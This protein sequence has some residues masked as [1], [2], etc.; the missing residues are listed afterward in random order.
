MPRL[1]NHSSKSS[2]KESNEKK[3]KESPSNS[4]SV[5]INSK[6]TEL[7]NARKFSKFKALL[8]I[9]P[10]SNKK[11]FSESIKKLLESS[12]GKSECKTIEGDILKFWKKHSKKDCDEYIKSS[13]NLSSQDNNKIK[14]LESSYDN[15]FTINKDIT[16]QLAKEIMEKESLNIDNNTRINLLKSWNKHDS[17]SYSEYIEEAYDKLVMLYKQKNNIEIQSIVNNFLTVEKTSASG[18]IYKFLKNIKVEDLSGNE[19]SDVEIVRT[20]LEIWS[21]KDSQSCEK[22]RNEIW[23]DW[24]KELTK[25]D[26]TIFS[27]AIQHIINKCKEQKMDYSDAD[28]TV[29][30]VNKLKTGQLSDRYAIMDK[31][32]LLVNTDNCKFA[33]HQLLATLTGS[34]R[35]VF[36]KAIRV[37]LNIDNTEKIYQI[38]FGIQSNGKSVG[39]DE[40]TSM[41]DKNA[42]KKVSDIILMF[43]SVAKKLKSE[44]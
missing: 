27:E 30:V 14:S 8:H 33:K 6:L 26:N 22:Y 7:Y 36:N 5:K 16:S 19:K 21:N 12:S 35:T 2:D 11:Q 3:P 39:A 9:L 10:R 4:M 17:N 31:N 40:L 34:I 44:I 42:D 41:M 25:V 24:K 32:D 28:F 15:F 18:L 20:I 1:F 38:K 13:F 23:N 29:S 43:N 37:G